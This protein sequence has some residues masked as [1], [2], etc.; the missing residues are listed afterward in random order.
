MNTHLKNSPPS[1]VNGRLLRWGERHAVAIYT[2]DGVCWVAEFRDGCG[3]LIDATTFFHF[4]A[5]TLRHADGRRAAA[6]ESATAL[7]QELLEKI[8]GLHRQADA[9]HSRRVGARAA[10][11]VPLQRYCSD[12]ASRIRGLASKRTQGLS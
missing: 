1:A 2:R 5:G 4:H 10:F 7:T 3:E 12:M 9:R 11:L 8:E 6:L